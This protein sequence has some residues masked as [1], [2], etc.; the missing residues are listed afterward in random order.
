MKKLPVTLSR[1]EFKQG[2]CLLFFQQLVLPELLI[3]LFTALEIPLTSA[4]LNFVY[5]LVNYLSALVVFRKFLWA[6][7][8]IALGSTLRVLS[9]VAIG[10]ALYYVLSN[11]LSYLIYWIDPEFFNLNDASIDSMSQHQFALMA[12]G[13][14]IL[15]PPAEELFFRGALFNHIYAKKP[16]L[17][18][19]IS[20]VSFCLVHLLGYIGQYTPLHFF[21]AFLQY[22]PAGIV[23][24]FA[25][26]RA[27]TIF[28]PILFHTLVN[29]L[30][31][32]YQFTMR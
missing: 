1:A 8:D 26:I 12:V 23:L 25:Y 16:I 15:V 31:M 21:L 29:A 27:G 14:V 24:C 5:F 3:L 28:A 32:Y 17:A 7:L 9:S 6:E 10:Y 20:T 2:L 4:E 30:A 11:T 19:F 22:I 13:T 18:C